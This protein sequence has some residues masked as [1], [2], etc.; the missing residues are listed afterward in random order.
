MT[1]RATSY[2]QAQVQATPLQ[3]ALVAATSPA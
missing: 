1:W 3:M 2:G